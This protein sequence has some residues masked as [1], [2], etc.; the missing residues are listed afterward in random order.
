MQLQIEVVG[1]LPQ[2]G[3]AVVANVIAT[4]IFVDSR[5]LY[6]AVA[7]D[8]RAEQFDAQLITDA[9]QV[10]HPFEILTTIFTQR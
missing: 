10:H 8:A 6:E 1:G 3:E 7:F 9:R 2:R 5:V 4:D